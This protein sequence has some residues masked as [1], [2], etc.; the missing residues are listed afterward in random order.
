MDPD[1]ARLAAR[2][3]AMRAALDAIATAYLAPDWVRLRARAGL[4][5]ADRAGEDAADAAML[6]AVGLGDVLDAD[7]RRLLGVLSGCP[8][9]WEE[10]Q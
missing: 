6:A 9:R 7:E 8:R 3:R 4:A 10:G 2:N 5:E 1:L